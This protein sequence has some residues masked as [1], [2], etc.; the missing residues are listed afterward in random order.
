MKKRSVLCFL[1]LLCILSNTQSILWADQDPSQWHLPEGA[2]ARLGKS[3]INDFAFSPD[4]SHLAVLSDVGVWIYDAL[5]GTEKALLIEHSGKAFYNIVFSPDGHNLIVFGGGQKA[6][7]WDIGTQMLKGTLDGYSQ[8]PSDVAFSPDGHTLAIAD[9]NQ[10]TQ[11]WDVSTMTLKSTLEDSTDAPGH[12]GMEYFSIAYSPN[13]DTFAIGAED[14]TI[15]LWDTSTATLKHTLIGNITSARNFSFSPDGNTIATWGFSETVWLW[16]TETG[17]HKYTIEHTYALRDINKSIAFSPDGR[18][19]AILGMSG[20]LLFDTVTGERRY[21]FKHRTA[22]KN[23]A[24]SPDGKTLATVYAPENKVSKVLLWDTSSYQHKHT[25]E[26]TD[27]VDSITFSSDGKTLTTASANNTVQTWNARTGAHIYT[28]EH[29][30]PVVGVMY[31][32]HKRNILT[33]VH[34]DKTVRVWN[35]ETRTSESS[36]RLTEHTKDISSAAFSPDGQKLATAS[37]DNV[38]LWDI[39]AWIFKKKLMKSN[40]REGPSIGGFSPDGESLA[41][42]KA[43]SD[44]YLFWMS[45]ERV[46]KRFKEVNAL[47]GGNTEWFKNVAY[48]PDGRTIAIQM[49][50]G[51]VMCD[52]ET[53]KIKYTFQPIGGNNRLEGV[54]YSPDGN[55]IATTSDGK[56]QL[57]DIQSQSLMCTLS[58]KWVGV[59]SAFSPDGDT[60]AT[61]TKSDWEPTVRLWD[62]TTGILENTLTGHSNKINSVTYSQDGNTLVTASQD[63]TVL[64]WYLTSQQQNSN[65]ED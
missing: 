7:L 29:T 32:P 64:L 17:T 37:Q 49:D 26:H 53:A 23:F 42:I 36:F 1:L 4:G 46:N 59:P 6:Q 54:L 55:T 39:S 41:V 35:T 3:P 57:W 19:I 27:L 60:I 33:T 20:L 34:S 52:A 11:L 50:T 40:Y 8:W 12:E 62:S 2:I 22:L 21:E 25:L 30:G 31:S 45:P 16:D 44:V 47:T 58:E 10:T 65:K 15:R 61:K 14:G 51:I 38:L 13:G 5:T 43:S 56:V 18:T 9:T 28:I 63:G 24:F 48:S